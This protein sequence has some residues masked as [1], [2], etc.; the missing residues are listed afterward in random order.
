VGGA[1]GV[2]PDQQRLVA[3]GLGELGQGQIDRLDVI[4]G[5]VGA[6]VARPEDPAQGL[7]G[8]IAAV[9]VAHQRV[10]AEATLVG[11]G[12]GLLVGVRVHSVPSTSTTSSPSRCAPDRQAAALA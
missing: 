5:G 12:R 3:S 9:Q 8:A 7:A 10:A 2:G 6:G 4:L 11:P 1:A